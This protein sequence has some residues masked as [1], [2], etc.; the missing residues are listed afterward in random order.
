MPLVADAAN[1][2]LK[3]MCVNYLYWSLCKKNPC[4][5]KKTNLRCI[6]CLY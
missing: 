4:R 5:V 6:S 2:Y 3:Q 1:I